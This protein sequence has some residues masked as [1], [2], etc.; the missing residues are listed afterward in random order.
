MMQK[1]IL[2]ALALTFGSTAAIAQERWADKLFI[3]PGTKEPYLVHDFGTVAHG[4]QLVYRF[5]M[6]NIYKVPLDITNLGVSCGCVSASFSKR[7]LQP[8]ETGYIEARMDTTKF[9]REKDVKVKVEVRNGAQ[10]FSWTELEVKANIRQDVVFNPGQ[11]NLGIVPVGST[12]ESIVE[13]AY[14]GALFGNWAITEVATNDVPVDVKFRLGGRDNLK[15]TYYVTV[16]LKKDAPAGA[17]KREIFLKTNDPASPSLPVLVEAI[18]QP[19]LEVTPDRFSI[20]DAKVGTPATRS[21]RLRG[22]RPFRILKVEGLTADITLASTVPSA[23]PNQIQTLTIKVQPA[24]AGEFKLE[25]KVTTDLQESP[26]I[27]PVE[28]AAQP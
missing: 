13:V 25:L 15:A 27:V 28:G 8:Q 17:L 19:L 4:A 7:T 1:I 11:V 5:E 9:I 22:E 21:V 20:A 16:A 2:G 10:F 6:T 24:K 14:A 12:R 23:A 18:I 3:K 26:L